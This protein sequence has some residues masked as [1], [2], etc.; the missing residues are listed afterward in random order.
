MRK[1]I[2]GLSNSLLKTSISNA[3]RRL[4][5]SKRTHNYKVKQAEK[6]LRKSIKYSRMAL[7]LAQEE[8][9]NRKKK[10]KR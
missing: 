9:K 1:Q 2:K 8:L 4:R 6:E 10:R 7:E 3:K 5:E